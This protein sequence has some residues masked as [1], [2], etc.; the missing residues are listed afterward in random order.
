MKMI[1]LAAVAAVF[2]TT[3]PAAALDIIVPL[4]VIVVPPT[5]TFTPGVTFVTAGQNSAS[6]QFFISQPM[7]LTVSSFTNSAIGGTGIFDFNSIGLFSGLGTGGDALQTGTISTR[8]N[9]IQTASLNP[10]QLNIGNYTINYAGTVSGEPAGVG[11]NITFAEGMA[12][13]GVPEPASWAMMIGGFGLVGG[14]LRRRR[15]ILRTTVSFA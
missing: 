3:S 5:Q 14:T 9:G 13:G 6:F 1:A 11:S 12:G 7:T 15:A 8:Q 10:F 2:A 4:G